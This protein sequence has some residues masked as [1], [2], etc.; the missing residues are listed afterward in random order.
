[1]NKTLL[2][3]LLVALCALSWTPVAEASSFLIVTVG[4]SSATCNNSTAGGVTACGAAG[5]T[6]SLGSNS[7]QFTGTVD[8]Y[9]FGGGGTVGLQVGGNA[10]GTASIAFVLDTKTNVQHV[11]GSDDAIIDF[12]TND[13]MLPVG[14]GLFLS[15]SNTANWTLSTAGDSM[16]FTAWGRDDNTLTAGPAGSTAAALSPMCLSSG[17]TTQS[18]A[19][20]TVD[21]PFNESPPFALT[22]RQVIHSAVGTVASYT[23]T[24]AALASPSTTV[25]EPSSLVL[26]GTGAA[27]LLS[28][29]NR[30]K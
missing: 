7:I 23:G 16:A 26:L 1:M 22:G 27:L 29:R 25:P 14:P 2:P 18:C 20:A 13:F 21:V 11:S 5:F 15:A 24:A 6:T 19:Q 9:S 10:P 17:G 4:G 8:G 30:R 3:C 28:R 12:G